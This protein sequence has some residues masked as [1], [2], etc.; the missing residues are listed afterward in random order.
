[1]FTEATHQH[2]YAISRLVSEKGNN[3][4]GE[5]KNQTADLPVVGAQQYKHNLKKK[6]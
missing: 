2:K 5:K 6:K 3:R 4:R 1:M